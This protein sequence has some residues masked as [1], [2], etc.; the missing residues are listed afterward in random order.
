M[1]SNHFKI[2]LTLTVV[3]KDNNRL[4]LINNLPFNTLEYS[5]IVIVL[6]QIFDAE[7]VFNKKDILKT[8][9]FQYHLEKRSSN[10]LIINIYKYLTYM[11]GVS[12][13]LLFMLYTYS[14]VYD[15]LTTISIK[16]E[17]LSFYNDTTKLSEIS[18]DNK[19]LIANNKYCLFEPFINLFSNTNHV[20]CYFVPTKLEVS[21]KDFNLLEY[22]IYNQ[23]A[24]LDVHTANYMEYITSL[25]SILEQYMTISD[26][27]LL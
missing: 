24:I 10:I 3:N 5:D 15:L 18:I 9:V 4:T 12:I 13:L 21:H 20:P 14:A 6:K 7:L 17:V 16:G 27:I 1:L 22:I 11:L 25:H 2:W 23:Q 26:K 8:I 19:E